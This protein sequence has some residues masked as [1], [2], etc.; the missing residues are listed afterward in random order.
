MNLSRLVGALTDAG[1]SAEPREVAEALWLAQHLTPGTGTGTGST[2]AERSAPSADGAEDGVEAAATAASEQP[3]PVPATAS[4]AGQAGAPPNTHRLRLPQPGG[5][6]GSA[7]GQSIMLPAA[8]AL[9]GKLP[10]G[11]ALRLL[12]RRVPDPRHLVVAEELSANRIAESGV[13]SPELRPVTGRWLDVAL[14]VDAEPSMR[15]WQPLVGELR[16][17]LQN[18]G[19]FRDVRTWSLHSTSTGKLG[20]SC[21]TTGSQRLRAPAELTDP[22]QRRLILVISDCVGTPWRDGTAGD[23]LY[24]WA[25]TM[26]VAIL[27]PLPQRMW[28]RT[29]LQPVHGRL[30]SAQAG[31]SNAHLRFTPHD[32]RRKVPP[33]TAPVPILQI[34]PDWLRP[35][36]R[37]VG[38]ET[39]GAMNS[40]VT[41]AAARTGSVPIETTR[42]PPAHPVDRV[43]YFRRGATPDAFRL[44]GYLTAV[45]LNLPIMRLVQ[46]IMLPASRPSHLAEVLLSGMLRIAPDGPETRYEFVDGVHAE[47]AG[48]L[49]RSEARNLRI[50]LSG[51]FADR[52]GLSHREFRAALSGPAEAPANGSIGAGPAFGS[53][54][55]ALLARLGGPF[56]DLTELFTVDGG[57]PS[58]DTSEP[59][60]DQVSDL[61]AAADALSARAWA[62]RREPED[63]ADAASPDPGSLPTGGDQSAAVAEAILLYRRALVIGGK[64][65]RQLAGLVR[66][67]RLRYA[68]TGARADLDEALAIGEE[69]LDIA[70]EQR[71]VSGETNLCD[72]LG[73]LR[74]ARFH[75]SAGMNDLNRAVRLLSRAVELTAPDDQE[76]SNRY[77]ALARAHRLRFDRTGTLSDL[78]EA[79]SMYQ[80]AVAF[81][82]PSAGPRPLADLA[83]NLRTRFEHIGSPGDLSAALD[84]QREAVAAATDAPERW[85][86]RL[87]LA[88]LLR[89][90]FESRGSLHDLHEAVDLYRQAVSIAASGEQRLH[91]SKALSSALATRFLHVGD[92]TDLDEAVEL[93]AGVAEA[94]RVGEPVHA[95]SLLAVSRLLLTRFAHSRNSADVHRAVRAG[96]RALES[97]PPRHPD[98]ATYLEQLGTAV[99]ARFDSEGDPLDLLEAIEAYRGAADFAPADEPGQRVRCLI[100]LAA[101]LRTRAEIGTGQLDLG[102]AITAIREAIE[103]S[104][105]GDRDLL[106]CRLLLTEFRLLNGL[107]VE[108]AIYETRTVID[109]HAELLG[110]QHPSSLAARVDLGR[111]LLRAGHAVQSESTLAEAFDMLRRVLGP[112]EPATLNASFQ[113]ARAL[114]RLGRS[115]EARRELEEV[116]RGQTEVLGPEHPDTIKSRTKLARWT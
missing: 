85:G 66:T 55:A 73:R 52:L 9:P 107:P 116:L 1:V 36:T 58:P 20:L 26:P 25:Q 101:A 21:G 65:P 69:A 41:F 98:H 39:G 78:D 34:E 64:Q 53:L 43:R 49:A 6:A 106:R 15:P 23:L 56:R 4:A 42:P 35:W 12:K 30:R 59:G 92:T 96:R 63:R 95:D 90:R 83:T 94:T 111:A 105:P 2:D 10:L 67:L 50:A 51:Y 81:A 3:S 16:S 8:D 86:F 28:Q 57:R 113:H 37:L 80:Q 40:A 44:A 91:S 108:D 14:V 68:L 110:H 31:T 84:A 77:T 17:V 33:G 5:S 103:I 27:Q 71:D 54:P 18:L 74:L 79:V 62:E 38:S 24:H 82:K 48:H 114:M 87:G 109:E 7:D 99:R 70:A 115:A 32:R 47:L 19:A 89:T 100:E 60:P 76:R 29:G 22:T 93:H 11:R 46:R 61:V 75:R 104:R 72:D 45:P 102:D 13:W 112:H 97:I 88:D